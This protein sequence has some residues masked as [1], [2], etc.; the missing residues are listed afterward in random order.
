M[1]R[2]ARAIGGGSNRDVK[3]SIDPRGEQVPLSRGE[4]HESPAAQPTVG[5]ARI[6]VLDDDASIR[7]M[8][9]LVLRG[10]GYEVMSAPDGA[11]G[12]DLARSWQPHLVV[13]DL[14]MP[15]VDG[16][17]FLARFRRESKT[18]VV[19]VSAHG[20]REVAVELGAEGWMEKPFDPDYLAELI[21]RLLH[22]GDDA[23]SP[24]LEP[25]R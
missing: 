2:T 4:P 17:E 22:T 19:I 25:R 14:R 6:L 23:S 18:P 1:P 8:L 13:L 3:F 5:T 15:I 16:R 20:A 24:A 12:L 7:R 11:Q 10:A 9:G 21:A